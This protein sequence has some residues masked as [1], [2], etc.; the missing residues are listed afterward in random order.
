MRNA[1]LLLLVLSALA[2]PAAAQE[3]DA[4]GV[5]TAVDVM[6]GLIGGIATIQPEYPEG[7][8]R[9]GVQGIVH[10]QFVVTRDGAV[11]DIVVT[12][13]V[14]PGIDA[15][16]VA[17][18]R[19]AR[20]TP[21]IHR[22]R[23]VPVRFTLPINFKLTETRYARAALPLLAERSERAA[24]LTRIPRGERVEAECGDRWCSV[25]YGGFTGYVRAIGL[26]PHPLPPPHR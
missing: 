11:S 14:S 17:A 18:L 4:S 20:F 19:P 24:L 2:A 1:A 23:R 12:R 26:S 10:L 25:S 13:S 3:P 22:G 16:A 7:E 8:R 6:P 15:A 21:G 5:Y 9:A